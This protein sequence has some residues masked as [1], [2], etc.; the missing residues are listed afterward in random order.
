MWEYKRYTILNSTKY[1]HEL[2]KKNSRDEQGAWEDRALDG[3]P[4]IQASTTHSDQ[5]Q[6]ES[7]SFKLRN[8]NMQVQGSQKL[9]NEW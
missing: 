4:M 7:T 2:Q 1:A 9:S 3:L 5:Q 8:L 6:G